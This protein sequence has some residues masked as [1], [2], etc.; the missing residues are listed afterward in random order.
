MITDVDWGNDDLFYTFTYWDETSMFDDDP[1]VRW[2]GSYYSR[3]FKVRVPRAFETCKDLRE[4]FITMM[5][6]DYPDCEGYW[7]E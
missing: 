3:R 2:D 5:Q 1:S 4:R 7:V 6:E